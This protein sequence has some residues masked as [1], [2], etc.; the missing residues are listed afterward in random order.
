VIAVSS[1]R[2]ALGVSGVI[3]IASPM[4]PAKLN[5]RLNI[6]ISI[7][8]AITIAGLCIGESWIYSLLGSFFEVALLLIAVR[9]A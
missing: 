2:L 6:S 5:R 3:V 8:Y 4:A 1:W 7:F 9:I